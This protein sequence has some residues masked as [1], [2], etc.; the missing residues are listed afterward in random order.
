MGLFSRKPEP[1]RYFSACNFMPGPEGYGAAGIDAKG[2]IVWQRTMA[3]RGHTLELSPDGALCAIID[4]K[5]GASI[6]FCRAADGGLLN[7]IAAPKGISFD[8][9]AVFNRSGTLLYATESRD[10]DQSGGIA[11]FSV[12]DG[13]RVATFPTHGIEPHE[14]IWA[15]PDRSLAIGNGGIRDKLAM[16]AEIES[17]LVLLD[18]QDGTLLAKHEL[19]ADLIS[20]SIRHLVQSAE[21]EIV[22]V[23]QDQDGGTDWRP[24]AGLLTRTGAIEFL[25]LPLDDLMRLRRCASAGRP[26]VANRCRHPGLA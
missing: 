1:A 3:A 17:S 22:F 8:G 26:W 11:G 6:T 4:R 19:D 12:A 20:L 9:H 5:P 24:M 2:R 15:E 23:M 25:D 14:L 21:G 16:E 7:R 18:V 10:G 13:T